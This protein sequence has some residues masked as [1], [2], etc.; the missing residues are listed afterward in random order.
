MGSKNFNSL[1]KHIK[2][3]LESFRQN[4]IEV[5]C[6]EKINTENL[7]KYKFL[8]IKIIDKRIT[9]K[10]NIFCMSQII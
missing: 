7:G 8:G 2:S 9:N 6:V 1:P 3:R 10:H 4:L 5:C